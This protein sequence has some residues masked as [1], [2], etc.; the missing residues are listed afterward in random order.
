MKADFVK[1]A[2]YQNDDKI[3]LPKNFESLKRLINSSHEYSRAAKP[4]L[5]LTAILILTPEERNKISSKYNDSKELIKYLKNETILPI[6]YFNNYRPEKADTR[7]LEEVIKTNSHAHIMTNLIINLLKLPCVKE[8]DYHELF[9]TDQKVQLQCILTKILPQIIK[10]KD[11]TSEQVYYLERIGDLIHRESDDRAAECIVRYLE[12]SIG[13][14]LHPIE[15]SRIIN[16]IQ[17]LAN[18]WEEHIV[19]KIESTII[20]CTKEYN[21]DT[22][23]GA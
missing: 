17:P 10:D 23:D 4:I 22:F 3:F 12:I 6:F 19:P 2:P 9:A 1:N 8:Q 11:L 16:A 18:F 20:G 15:D 21:C 14:L 5:D 7:E 13:N